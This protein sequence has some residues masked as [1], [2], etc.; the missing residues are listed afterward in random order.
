VASDCSALHLHLSHGRDRLIQGTSGAWQPPM[1]SSQPVQPAPLQKLGSFRLGD[2][3][4]FYDVTDSDS[5]QEV[6]HPAMSRPSSAQD[7]QSSEGAGSDP[8]E[9]RSV[10]G[11]AWVTCSGRGQ[12]AAV[13]HG[14]QQCS[15]HCTLRLCSDCGAGFM[16]HGACNLVPLATGT[17]HALHGRGWQPASTPW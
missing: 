15:M 6:Y 12:A 17:T 11:D 7:L 4:A 3:D 9:A 8:G 13:Q 14:R 16:R 2:V 1:S 10:P 5:E